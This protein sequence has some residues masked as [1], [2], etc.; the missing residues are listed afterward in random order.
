MII[1][2]KKTIAERI[3]HRHIIILSNDKE[4]SLVRQKIISYGN[5]HLRKKPRA[6]E[7]NNIRIDTYDGF[8]LYKITSKTTDYLFK[9]DINVLRGL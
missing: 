4:I 5:L 3:Y 1:F 2:Q 7:K 9:N 8:F 6:T